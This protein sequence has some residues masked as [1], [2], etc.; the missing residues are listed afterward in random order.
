MKKFALL[1]L[2]AS[3]LI[4]GG[5]V[6]QEQADA[7]MSKGCEAALMAKMGADTVKD[8]K[9]TGSEAQT[10]VD[11]EYRKINLT[12][13]ETGSFDET[14]LPAF[15][16]FNEQWGIG[17]SSHTAILDQLS[18]NGDIS[19]KQGG[20]VQGDLQDFLKLVDAAASGM[21]Q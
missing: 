10:T 13:V 16:L 17:K 3:T 20:V 1:T 21:G 19:G 4:L 9:M 18:V 14:P 8:V 5:C 7:K 11:G 2:A 15:C 6:N 12:Y